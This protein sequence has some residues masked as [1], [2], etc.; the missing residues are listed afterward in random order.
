M[1][2]PVCDFYFE[3]RYHSG[4]VTTLF[5]HP[6]GDGALTRLRLLSELERVNAWKAVRKQGLSKQLHALYSVMGVVKYPCQAQD[7][8]YVEQVHA[9]LHGGLALIGGESSNAAVC[10]SSVTVGRFIAGCRSGSDT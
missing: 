4:I 1:L 3:V 9:S 10:G 5:V 8:V 2:G 7:E 6:S